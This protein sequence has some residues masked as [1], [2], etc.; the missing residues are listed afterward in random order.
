[1]RARVALFGGAA[2]SEPTPL[3]GDVLGL[4]GRRSWEARERRSK[5]CRRAVPL[6]TRSEKGN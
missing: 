3:D 5:R 2:R 1:M 4:G 6:E